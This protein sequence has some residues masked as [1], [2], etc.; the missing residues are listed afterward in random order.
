MK[1]TVDTRHDSLEEAL[2]T[3]HAAFGS[4][5]TQPTSPGAIA[6]EPATAPPAT[7]QATKPARSRKGTAA[8]P[9]TKR[10]PAK[11][12]PATSA[13]TKTVP[14]GTSASSKTPGK[15]ARATRASTRNGTKATSSIT[16]TS[17]IAP[18]GQADAIRAWA[19]AR[20][21][22]VKQAGRLP[23][24]AIQAYQDSPDH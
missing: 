8:R 13:A 9:A 23:A 24:A 2:A 21:M 22:K 17:N 18:P 15:T 7:R 6:T 10:S 5:T 3:V 14:N 12:S 1:V 16:P 20:G 11:R 4:S 19:Q